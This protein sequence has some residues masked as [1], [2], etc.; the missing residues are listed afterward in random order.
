MKS[1]TQPSLILAILAIFVS[2]QAFAATI[3][4]NAIPNP[5]F[6]GPNDTERYDGWSVSGWRNNGKAENL[7]YDFLTDGGTGFF[8]AEVAID[9]TSLSAITSDPDYDANTALLTGL[10]FGDITAGIPDWNVGNIGTRIQGSFYC[11][12]VFSTTDGKDYSF[13]SNSYTV[14]SNWKNGL[15]KLT[16]SADS[17]VSHGVFDGDAFAGGG[18]VLSTI[19]NMKYRWVV[20]V[21][22]PNSDGAGDVFFLSDDANLRYT[23]T[24]VSGPSRTSNTPSD[25]PDRMP[26]FAEPAG[27][28]G[29]ELTAKSRPEDSTIYVGYNQTD[30]HPTILNSKPII[31]DASADKCGSSKWKAAR[32]YATTSPATQAPGL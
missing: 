10:S 13:R 31:A 4:G 18:I 3:T 28:P 30:R 23:V 22:T 12:V 5:G 16:W 6:T 19:R 24:T 11:E 29:P 26:A 25:L 21:K 8:V 15:R 7:V 32:A 1:R 20:W 14:D 9:L 27:Q 17:W 2:T